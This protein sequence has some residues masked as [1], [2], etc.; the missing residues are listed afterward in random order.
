MSIFA[1]DFQKLLKSFVIADCTEFQK[2]NLS[3][4]V[5]SMSIRISRM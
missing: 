1:N 3:V 5:L 4:A 2:E